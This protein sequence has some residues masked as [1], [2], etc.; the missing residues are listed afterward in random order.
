[1]NKPK[2]NMAAKMKFGSNAIPLPQTVQENNADAATMDRAHSTNPAS[3]ECIVAR[4][5][6]S[7]MNSSPTGTKAAIGTLPTA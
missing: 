6:D 1:M 4:S 5:K 3:N 7:G 2:N